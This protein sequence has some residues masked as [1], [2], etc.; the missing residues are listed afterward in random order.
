[1][2]PDLRARTP[3]PPPRSHWVGLAVFSLMLGIVMVRPPVS[4]DVVPDV[5]YQAALYETLRLGQPWGTALATTDGPLAAVQRPAYVSGSVWMAMSWQIAGN[6]LLAVVLAVAAW[7]L[8]W[9]RRWWA[10]ALL[11]AA[12]ARAPTLA[13]WLAVVVIGWILVRERTRAPWAFLLGGLLGFLG[14]S[15]LGYLLLGAVAVVLTVATSRA[16]PV[17]IAAAGGFVVAMLGG[18]M[19]LGQPLS[20]FGVW[21]GR[22]FPLLWRTSPLLR[23]GEMPPLLEAWAAAAGL[24]ALVVLLLVMRR[25]ERRDL[26]PA[27]AFLI[28]A[29][30]LAWKAVALQ[31]FGAAGVFFGTA[32]A[33]AFLLLHAGAG[34]G[35]AVLIGSLA[36]GGLVRWQPLILTDA[37][38]GVNRQFLRNVELLAALPG[39]REALHEQ[40]RQTGRIHQLPRVREAVG[41]ATVDV[42]GGAPGHALFNQLNLRARPAPFAAL[43]R[44]PAI[45]ELNR[46]ALV[47]SGAPDFLL[48][49]VQPTEGLLPPLADSA[50]LLALYRRYEFILEEEGF[51]LWKK[52][53][54]PA[55]PADPVRVAEGSLALG[56]ALELPPPTGNTGYWLELDVRPTWLGR[57]WSAVGETREPEILLHDSAGNELRYTLLDEIASRGFLIE[58]FIRGEPDLLRLKTAGDL[59]RVTTITLFAPASSSWRWKQRA[60]FRLFA[61]PGIELKEDRLPADTLDRFRLFSR[62]PIATSYFLPIK[63]LPSTLGFPIAFAHPVSTLEFAVTA[64]DERLRVGFGILAEAYAGSNASDGVDF[65]IEFVGADGVRATL[66]HRHLDPVARPEDG[67][68]QRVEIRLP[69]ERAGRLILR[70]FNPPP[71]NHA[72]DWSYWSDIIIGEGG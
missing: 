31:P 2:N 66:L 18:W 44:S 52:R 27:A 14:L 53:T 11:L 34:L 70:T 71:R 38:G 59:P 3:R 10:I 22:A 69:E 42:I 26:W 55:G 6:L 72:W 9:P 12:L 15:S 16:G 1:M 17:R 49:R 40:V 20:A 7:R 4:V 43:V 47:G 57:L 13:P 48:Q 51:L 8:T 64:Q 62:T 41:S 25:R 50:V 28:A 46:Q 37:V 23:S 63:V 39:L 58:P 54:A 5:A 61:A 36:F 24:A 60:V 56:Q 33:V 67:G 68:P 29:G 32:L 45:V 30:A 35:R 65:S 19:V 21:L